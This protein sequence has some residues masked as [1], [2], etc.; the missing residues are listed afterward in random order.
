MDLGEFSLSPDQLQQGVASLSYQPFVL[1]DDLCTGVAYSWVATIEGGRSQSARDFVLDRRTCD[2][3]LWDR[4]YDAN[5]RLAAMYDDFVAAVARHVPGGTLLDVACNNGYF[6]IR[7]AQQG[8]KHCVGYDLEDY[9]PAIRFL[10]SVTGQEV[11]F[12]NAAYDSWTHE[13]PDCGQYDVVVASNIVQHIPDPLYF[14]N[15]LGS[16]ARK[17]LFLFLGVG[18]T[19]QYLVY[20]SNPNRFYKDRKF[21]V[22]F[23]NDVGMS[24]GLL[25]ASLRQLGFSQIIELPRKSTWLPDSFLDLGCQKALLCLR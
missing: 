6:L 2:K 4:F 22:N 20:Y 18:D 8:M 16:R 1:S 14:L 7:G 3:D 15:F 25:W 21:P 23:D 19:D 24:R 9:S 17:A 13:I 5:R 12:V 10:N 11:E